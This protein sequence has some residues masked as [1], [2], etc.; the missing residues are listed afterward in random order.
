MTETK[1]KRKYKKRGPRV[2]NLKPWQ[3]ILWSKIKKD[4]TGEG[5]WVWMGSMN[6][7]W[8]KLSVNRV[9]HNDVMPSRSA[10]LLVRIA[11]GL[12]TAEKIFLHCGEGRCVNPDH[13]DNRFPEVNAERNLELRSKWQQHLQFLKHKTTYAA[14]GREFG[15]TRERV[16]QLCK[17]V[18]A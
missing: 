3:E 10:R 9:K 1:K 4:E 17:G 14:L 18:R 16:R 5:H 13:M 8:P 6:N 7:G 12:P 15:L 11:L 2:Y